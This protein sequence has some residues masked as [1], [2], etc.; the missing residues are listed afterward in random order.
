MSEDRKLQKQLELKG[1]KDVPYDKWAI[2]DLTSGVMLIM[3][4]PLIV[5]LPVETLLNTKKKRYYDYL[6]V[7]TQTL[8]YM[9]FFF[10]FLMQES[11]SKTLLTLMGMIGD[12][13]TFIFLTGWY[14]FVM[15]AVFTTLY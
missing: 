2:L 10:F 9:R 13:L 3:V 5:R 7:A 12:T 14:L 8:T 15:A 11:I 1:N 6:V 4:V